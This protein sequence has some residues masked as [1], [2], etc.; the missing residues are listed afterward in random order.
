MPVNRTFDIL[1]D[2]LL[3]VAV[4]YLLLMAFPT[5]SQPYGQIANPQYLPVDWGLPDNVINSDQVPGIKIDPKTAADRPLPVYN[6]ASDT[7]MFLGSISILDKDNRGFNGNAGF[8][9]TS[10]GVV[11]IDTLG[12]PM[13]G[14]RVIA[15]IRSLTDKPIRYLIV[16]HNHPDHSY[17]AGAFTDIEGIT[18]IA[19]KG[20]AQ[21]NLSET[22]DSSVEYRREVLPGDMQGFKPVAADNYIDAESFTSYRIELGDDVFDIY[23]TGKHHSHG[24]LVVH[25]RKQDVVWISDL[26]FNQRT[27]F[28][29]D[30]HSKQIILALDWLQDNFSTAKLMVPGHGSPQ[31]APFPMVS[32][33]R[34]YVQRLRDAM[35]E[36]VDEGVEI[37]DAV[38]NVEFSDWQGSYLYEE[39]HK[40]NANFIY[41]EMEQALFE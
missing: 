13:L 8:I 33:T 38:R 6:I 10:E 34:D 2:L 41:L 25:Q 3:S 7:Y 23:N 14:R 32:K 21:Y 12:T 16:T 26:A 22:L 17:G 37:Y 20:T 30:G 1:K 5:W 35:A 39:N 11:V 19:H 24:D 40:A 18:V 36:A 15:T 9:V 28:L 31:T 29:G 4:L 27:T